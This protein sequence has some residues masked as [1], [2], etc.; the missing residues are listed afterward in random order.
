MGKVAALVGYA[1]V[2]VRRYLAPL[3]ALRC[4]ALFRAQPSPEQALEGFEKEKPGPKTK[5]GGKK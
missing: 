4:T 3:R 2:Y 1:L 5:K